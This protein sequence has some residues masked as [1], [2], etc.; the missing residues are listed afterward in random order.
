M[1]IHHKLRPFASKWDNPGRHLAVLAVSSLFLAPAFAAAAPT[2]STFGELYSLP[3][4]VLAQQRSVEINT[5]VLCFDAD[6]AQLFVDSS[7]TAV[8][9]S[10]AGLHERFEAGDVVRVTGV[11]ATAPLTLP[12]TNLDVRKIGQN[13]LP[14]AK[15]LSLRQLRSAQGAWVEF[16][17]PVRTADTSRGRLELELGDGS[18]NCLV[19]VMGSCPTND[20][21]AYIGALMR[22]RGIVTS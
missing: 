18:E 21:K 5:T 14:V 6:W 20:C 13:Q 3:A 10:P 1:R 17:A 22:V 9:I 8:F 16:V 12:I 11:T 19:Y 2:V 7:P 15:S 4:D